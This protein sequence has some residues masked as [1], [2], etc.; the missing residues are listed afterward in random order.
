M[1]FWRIFRY[2]L[3][4]FGRIIFYIEPAM[5]IVSFTFWYKLSIN[6][7]NLQVPVSKVLLK[8]NCVISFSL[9]LWKIKGI[10]P[11]FQILKN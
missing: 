7:I 5:I 2:T 11:F 3:I 9:K 10:P 1:Q 6:L 8:N 4:C